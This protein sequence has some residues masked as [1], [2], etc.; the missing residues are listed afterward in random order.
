MIYLAA[1]SVVVVVLLLLIVRKR[2]ADKASTSVS[3]NR[4]RG[5]SR[6][7]FQRRIAALEPGSE[8]TLFRDNSVGRELGDPKR[9]I[10]RHKAIKTTQTSLNLFPDRYLRSPSVLRSPS[11][12]SKVAKFTSRGL[13]TRAPRADMAGIRHRSAD[14]HR[15]RRTGAARPV[16]RALR[17]SY[18]R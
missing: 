2:R 14:P 10:G 11:S 7:T 13:W 1:A 8:K 15:S 17:G 3:T 6:P 4:G 16:V 12:P 9:R 5:Q 18:R